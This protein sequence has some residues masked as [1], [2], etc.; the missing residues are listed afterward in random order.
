MFNRKWGWTLIMVLWVWGQG[1]A[2][3]AQNNDKNG[4][5]TRIETTP[6]GAVVY[7]KGEYRLAGRAPFVI[8]QPLIGVYE[9]KARKRG[10]ETY[11]ATHVFRPGLPERLQ[12]RLTRKTRL[13]AMIRSMFVPGWGQVYSEHRFKGVV[14][15]SAQLVSGLYLLVTDSRYQKAVDAFNSAVRAF[16]IY[17]KNAEVRDLYIQKIFETQKDVDKHY[18]IRKRALIIAASIYMYNLLD[19]L[20]LFPSFKDN[21]PGV[22]IKVAMQQVNAEPTLGLGVQARF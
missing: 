2:A 19:A 12:I 3:S 17:E 7:L 4:G 18:E 16:K 13:R 1:W 8:S 15:G 9:I 5:G 14:L 6:G 10:Y 20:I 22:R 11:A 21:Q